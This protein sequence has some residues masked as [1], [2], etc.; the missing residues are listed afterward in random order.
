M[1]VPDRWL[2]VVRGLAQLTVEDQEGRRVGPRREPEYSTLVE[3]TIP[4]A[5]YSPGQVFSSVFLNQPGTYTFMLIAQAPHN[6]HL[7]LKRY[8][9]SSKFDTFFFQGIP[10]I[11]GA[12]ARLV[13]DTTEPS[14]VP[15]LTV[16]REGNGE[17]ERIQPT[18]LS[19][20]ASDDTVP[21]TTQIHINDNVVIVSATDNP[22]GAGV[23]RTYYTT[24]GVTRT[25]Y[26]EPF[27]VP[28]DAKILM[29]YSED[30]AGNLEYPGAVWPVFG[31]SHDNFVLNLADS[32]NT[33]SVVGRNQDG[34]LEVFARGTD[35]GL[36]HIYELAPNGSWSGWTSLGGEIT[37]DPCVVS[38]ADGRL[39]IFARGTDNALWHIW[40]TA[41]SD[42]W[43]DWASLWGESK[44]TSDPCVVSNA[45][46][47]LEIFAHGTDGA[48][49]HFWQTAPNNGW[50]G[51][52]SLGGDTQGS[53]LTTRPVVGRNQDGR[54]EVFA[55]GT[56]NVL[57][58]IYELAPNGSW[59]GWTSLGGEITSDPC[60]ASNADGRLEIFARGTD[61]ALWHIWQT[62]PSNG[63][64]DWGSLYGESKITSD[65]CVLSNADGRLEIFARGTDGALW[66]I[67][68]TA[69]SNGWSGWASLAASQIR[70]IFDLPQNRARIYP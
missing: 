19:P 47:R 49:W 70:M 64:S 3:N 5:T 50:S 27:P 60:V 29:A 32:L 53:S 55:R 68:Q 4:G 26:I 23:L 39:E 35:N 9:S 69:P 8:N 48:L 6:M 21:P 1:L 17:S 38:N 7:S 67:W 54:L 40:Q 2:L 11:E 10:M 25:V 43:S 12:I 20:Q 45:D 51:W 18:I 65:P 30:R 59:S 52:A 24:D 16:D 41:P 33:R 36:W 66:H 28:P 13:Y 44:I 63:W 58:H 22:G 56:D 61:N 42:G 62:A 57:W 31:L 46:G 37:S 15:V 14:T 34:R